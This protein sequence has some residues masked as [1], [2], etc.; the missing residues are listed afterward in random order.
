MDSHPP[1]SDVA[2]FDLDMSR[3]GWAL[4][5]LAFSLNQ[6]A[7]RQSFRA[8]PE[9]YMARFELP[10]AQRVMVR[11]RDFAAMLHAGGNINF[12]LKLGVAMG[13]TLYH[14]GAQMRGLTYEAFMATRNVQGVR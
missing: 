3:K 12:L 10:E 4:N 9:A 7:N 11:Q 6:E 5:K 8:D 1:P 14:M 13:V 2:P